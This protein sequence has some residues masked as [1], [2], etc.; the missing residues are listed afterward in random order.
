MQIF[1]SLWQI[2]GGKAMD[3]EETQELA[4]PYE[5]ISVNNRKVHYRQNGTEA[6][7]VILDAGLH[8]NSL[9][10]NDL[11]PKISKISN[12]IS[13]DRAGLGWSERNAESK[14][15]SSIY[16]KELF[17]FI[18]VLKIQNPVVLVGHSAAGIYHREF[19]H[20]YPEWVAGMV[21]I[22]SSHE[23][24]ENRFRE[25]PEFI[26]IAN[27]YAEASRKLNT[28]YSKMTHA[29]ILADILEK[30]GD[31]WKDFS[32][33]T[34]KYHKDRE[35]PQLYKYYLELEACW[36][37]DVSKGKDALHSLGD[38]PII[39][40]T[41]SKFDSPDFSE[42]QSEKYKKIWQK[43]QHEI[44]SLSSDSKQII[45]DSGHFIPYEKPEAVTDAIAE[46]VAKVRKKNL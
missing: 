26:E 25:E 30:R 19:A 23:D 46:I 39:V 38:I 1:F 21:F 42:A 22:D 35:R 4:P 14:P 34:S 11:H 28:K 44:V 7:T 12:V 32:E 9:V 33:E 29:E 24:V 17:E 13:Y 15:S 45:V 31:I 2:L 20:Q 41:A 10:F 18:K 27:A 36:E 8:G 3:T 6:P 16:A 40:L 5:I 43:L 37:K